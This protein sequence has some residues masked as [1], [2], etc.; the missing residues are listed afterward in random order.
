MIDFFKKL[1][2]LIFLISIASWCGFGIYN[3][4]HTVDSVGIQPLIKV[5]GYLNNTSS[6]VL[7]GF[8]LPSYAPHD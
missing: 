1:I 3:L 8:F 4:S 6:F 5:S 2:S 7:F